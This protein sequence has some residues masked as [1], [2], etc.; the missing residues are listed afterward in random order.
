MAPGSLPAG[1]TVEGATPRG[2]GRWCDHSGAPPSPAR[3]RTSAEKTGVAPSTFSPPVRRADAPGEAGTRGAAPR[4]ALPHRTRGIRA[5]PCPM[6]IARNS[7][8]HNGEGGAL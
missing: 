5:N 2:E 4:C 7:P 1:I 6:R 3:W 8:D